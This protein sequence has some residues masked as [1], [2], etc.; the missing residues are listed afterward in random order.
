M[1]IDDVFGVCRENCIV[2]RKNFSSLVFDDALIDVCSVFFAPF[3]KYA[4]EYARWYYK[5]KEI[6]HIVRMADSSGC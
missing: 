2:E 6:L 3:Q 1:G 4:Y 5:G